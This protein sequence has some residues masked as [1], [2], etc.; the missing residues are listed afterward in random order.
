MHRLAGLLETLQSMDQ[1][2]AAATTLAAHLAAVA[3]E[4]AAW[5]VHLLTAESKKSAISIAAL[6]RLARPAVGLPDWLFDACEQVGGDLVE[7]VALLL[8]ESAVLQEPELARW[9]QTELPGLRSGGEPALA[10]WLC[11]TAPQYSAGV[12]RLMLRLLL[13]QPLLR[14]LR[15]PLRAVLQQALHACSQADPATVQRRLASTWLGTLGTPSA[16]AWQQLCAAPTPAERKLPA[17]WAPA[18]LTSHVGSMEHAAA[19]LGRASDWAAW[20]EPALAGWQLLATPVGIELWS[21]GP[22][23]QVLKPN[24]GLSAADWPSGT[25]LQVCAACGAPKPGRAMVGQA[26]AGPIDVAALCAVDLWSAAGVDWRGTPWP[27]RLARRDALAVAAGLARWPYAQ[28]EDWAG[29]DRLRQHAVR[30]GA[31]GLHLAQ[32]AS[33]DPARP[34]DALWLAP[35][36]EAL[37]VLLYAEPAP[38]AQADADAGPRLKLTLAAWSRPPRDAGEVAAAAQAI[39]AR[40][41]SDAAALHLV[42]VARCW[43]NADAAVDMGQTAPAP[44]TWVHWLRAQRLAR[45]GPVQHLG[46][47]GL[48]RVSYAAVDKSPRHRAGLQLRQARVQE[49]LREA[50][51]QAAACVDDLRRLLPEDPGNKS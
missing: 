27:L 1:A 3:P 50:D 36:Q 37:L 30:A 8:P 24:A 31:P 34:A 7:T 10:Q 17:P 16:D 22:Q 32:C 11:G 51:A 6:R 13:H 49:L 2:P 12:R 42:A 35:P 43:V 39:A 33:A 15:W 47:R 4:D 18:V 44:C 14:G 19:V 46:P 45:F 28:G 20:A 26:A 25:R 41:A 23:L 5:C 40:Q 48:V 9:M 21:P 29:L 38:D